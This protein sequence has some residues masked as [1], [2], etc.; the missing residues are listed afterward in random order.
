MNNL[1]PLIRKSDIR[2]SWRH[3]KTIKIY[4]LKGSAFNKDDYYAE[5]ADVQDGKELS[6]H[7]LL[8]AHIRDVYQNLF[9]KNDKETR[10]IFKSIIPSNVIYASQN[11]I[12]WYNQPQERHLIFDKEYNV[13]SAKYKIPGLLFVL[14]RESADC[15]AFKEPAFNEKN[16]LYIG[17]FP[18]ITDGAICMGNVD[19][20]FES[21][22][23]DTIK[24]FETGFFNSIF[25]HDSQPTTKS[26]PAIYREMEKNQSEFPLKYLKPSREKL[27]DLI[28][29][30]K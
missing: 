20:D 7:G 4:T 30:N 2:K 29:D 3:D 10:I 25:T 22:Y 26:L 9:E 18:N 23:E 21:T 11:C 1:Q 28:D 17:P 13:K 8:P 14:T 16:K 12:I 5:I 19:I 27:S 24:K 6:F 15:Y